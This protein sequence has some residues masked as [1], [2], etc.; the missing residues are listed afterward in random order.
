M[1]ASTPTGLGAAVTAAELEAAPLAGTIAGL[2]WL[3]Q[4]STSGNASF[5]F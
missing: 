4:L 2:K 1:L 5:A 3:S